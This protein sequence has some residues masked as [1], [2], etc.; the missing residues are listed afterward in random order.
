M[1]R[2][3]LERLTLVITAGVMLYF[4]YI[5]MRLFGI[6]GLIGTLLALGIALVVLKFVL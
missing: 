6:A 3:Q 1:E 4:L 2:K 5:Q